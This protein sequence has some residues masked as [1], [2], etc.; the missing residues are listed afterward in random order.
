MR[1]R[2]EIY[3]L[4]NVDP[5]AKSYILAKIQR[6]FNIKLDNEDLKDV[7]TF[8]N[9]GDLVISTIAHSNNCNAQHAFYKVRSA[10]VSVTGI[11]KCSIKPQTRLSSI[12][13]E[14]NRPEVLLEIEN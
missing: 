4:N 2:E 8:G 12:L 9:L 11:D 6:L 1:M 13:T 14:E 3:L 7:D 10:I 5:D